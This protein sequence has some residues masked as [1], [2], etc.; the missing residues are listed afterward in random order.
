MLINLV[1][2]ALKFTKNGRIVIEAT[3]DVLQR[4]ISIKVKDTGMGIQK[5]DLKLLFQPYG[6]LQD[7]TA[8]NIEGIG[9]GLVI[10]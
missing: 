7:L 4:C 1:K 5:E 6:K 10:C 3:Y 9:L 8:S 2:N